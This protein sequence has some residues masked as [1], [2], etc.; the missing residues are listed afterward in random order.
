M[1]ET[2]IEH[3]LTSAEQTGFI[4]RYFT[5]IR[6]IILIVVT[7]AGAGLVVFNNLPKELNPDIKIPIV[8]VVT[9]YPGASPTDV[10]DLITV[11]LEDAVNSV[12]GVTKSTSSS[13]EG[14]SVITLEFASNID[15]DKAKQ[16]VQDQVDTVTEIPEDAS[17]TNLQVVD[18]QDQPVLT[19]A[20]TGNTDSQTLR[21]ATE[22]LEETL[23]NLPL[24]EKV[25]LSANLPLEVSVV[26]DQA[27]I[28]N[29]NLNI[30]TLTETLNRILN[31]APGGSVATD[32]NSYAF[33]VDRSIASLEELRFLPITI[34]DRTFFLGDLATIE[35]KP[36][37]RSNRAFH[38][39]G[40][41]G[42]TPAVVFSVYKIDAANAGDT[43]ESI[44]EA[45][46]QIDVKY[47]GV[48]IYE[49]IFDGAKEIQKS[50]DQLFKDFFLT[51]SLVFCILIIFFGLR[52]SVVSS[53]AIPLTFLITFII[54][55][56]V[57][58]SI[59]FIALF[60][61]LL[62]LGIL[63]DNVIVIIS[64]MASYERQGH[65]S[66]K[67]SALLVWRDYRSVIFTTTITT[68]WAFLPLL[69][70]SGIIGEFIKPI[71]IVVS[72]SLA[73]SA[74]LALFV[75]IPLMA[76]LQTGNFARRV[77]VL[78]YIL[79]FVVGATLV[80]FLLPTGQYKIPLFALALVPLALLV[81]Q[82]SLEKDPALPGSR[83]M[84]VKKSLRKIADKGFLDLQPTA[85]RYGKFLQNILQSKRKR[86]RT[87]IALIIFALFSYAL[88]PLGFVVN[89]FFPSDDQEIVYVAVTLPKGTSLD[90]SSNEAERFI[91]ALQ[92]RDQ[93]R[94]V[95]AETSASAPNE[96]GLTGSTNQN[97]LLFTVLLTPKDERDITSDEF[98]R[99]LNREFQDRYPNGE[100]SASQLSGGPPAGSDLQISFLGDDPQVIEQYTRQVED[101]LKKEPGVSQVKSSLQTGSGKIVFVPHLQQIAEAGVS[102]SSINYWVRALGSGITLVE[103]ARFDGE[104]RD[105]VLRLNQNDAASP[106]EAQNLL[107]PTQNGLQPLSDFGHFELV[108]N[109][110][111]IDRE[112]GKQ[113]IA[114]SAA[115]SDEFSVSETNKKLE[116][117]AATLDLPIGYSW[118]TGGVNEE[119]DKSVQS[120]L[121]AM[122]LSAVLIFATMTVQF[123]SF[124]K[125]L[126]VLLAIPMAISGV[127]IVFA[128]T[129]TPLS[130]PALIGILA[131]FG[132]VVNNSIIMVD[133]INRNMDD[134]L[135]LI[136]A[137]SEGASSRLEPILLTA[138]TTIVGLI[139]ITLS[140]P[141]WQGLGGAI[142]A[143]LLFSGVAKLFLIPVLYYAFYGPREIKNEVVK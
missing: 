78:G 141:I 87:F 124:R 31:N 74:L 9:A 109:P 79:A 135:P 43:V 136:E 104:K 106:A 15:P 132:I 137:I 22:E 92:G 81:W 68:I 114:V 12:S 54:M 112:D 37:A 33:G 48:F 117:F 44:R 26:L 16:D 99:N 128:L 86:K 62:A 125:S 80:F 110:T 49:P 53:F 138:L 105:I 120:I 100:F 108:S 69:L 7:L 2:R 5:N 30:Q 17:D 119:N 88:V 64:A 77:I 63:V 103:D 94:F 140:D 83:R 72:S 126:I 13:Q 71:P 142:I 29:E 34:D 98:V 35:E 67:E 133:K 25:N 93:V 19:F 21:L 123:R 73:V 1:Q 28:R 60:S 55:G 4:A 58:I 39:A 40:D 127:F 61:L 11:P 130:F 111:K 85:N 76:T 57:G 24:V 89:E 101:F 115:V 129:G 42:P 27:K 10:K 84:R 97:E 107:I 36:A 143:G 113:T 122:I 118:K 82:F 65:H 70:A 41:K 91:Q 96:S 14:L 38:A 139:P 32:S 59:N 47:G 134:N 20:W 46:N 56:V 51:V 45:A 102:E 95:L 66:P 50:F 116:N 75:V 8:T 90:A 131:L 23:K 3:E 121:Q 18:F 6:T 52:Q